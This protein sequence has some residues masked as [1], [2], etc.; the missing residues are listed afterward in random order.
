MEKK[1]LK[2][3]IANFLI[4]TLVSMFVFSVSLYRHEIT[5]VEET[6]DYL[7]NQLNDSYQVV[8]EETDK[9]TGIYIDNHLRC[10]NTL[11][12]ILSA[13]KDLHTA[14]GLSSLKQNIGVEDIYLIT[15]EGLIAVS[16]NPQAVGQYFFNT[17]ETKNISSVV[18][19][20][21]PGVILQADEVIKGVHSQDFFFKKSTVDGY[22]LTMIGTDTTILDDM[23]NDVSI[24]KYIEKTPTEEDVCFMILDKES[25]EILG[26]TK[27][28]KLLK[29]TSYIKNE[30]K[31]KLLLKT[32]NE[33]QM[34]TFNDHKLFAKSIDFDD[35]MLVCLIETNNTFRSLSL[36]LLFCAMV[37]ICI[38]VVS[39]ILIKRHFQKYV[40]DEFKSIENTVSDLLQGKENVEFSP[41]SNKEISQMVDVLNN[42]KTDFIYK[43]KQISDME[44]ELKDAVNLSERD[45]L[46]GLINRCGYETYIRKHL[47]EYPSDGIF[48]MMDVDNFKNLN[49]TLG[50]PEGDRALKIIADFLKEEFRERD[51]IARLGGDEFSIFMENTK[52]IDTNLLETK[53]EDLILDL[54]A[55]L[56]ETYKNCGL[57]ISI[58]AVF[59]KNYQ[60]V[61]EE[62]YQ[63]ADDALYTAKRNGKN[64]YFIK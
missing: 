6:L 60:P 36:R 33:L 39:I 3:I 31:L 23:E 38:A 19:D 40:F 57:S 49:D 46:T 15:K 30:E 9:Q 25:G 62:L 41:N 59:V 34:L 27:G 55:A 5:H 1:L 26:T 48:L 2:N 14:K 43:G 63:Y 50:H 10:L 29:N 28:D 54:H 58:G 37:L 32:P 45:S 17:P 7:L 51:T 20:Y 4:I 52:R 22:F 53:L 42:W 56:P 12:Y 35:I 18:R 8:E 64:G 47:C 44:M 11:N 21:D 16:T 24:E 13:N 61:Y